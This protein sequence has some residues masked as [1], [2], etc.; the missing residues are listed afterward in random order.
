ML[1]RLHIADLAS[2]SAGLSVSRNDVAPLEF[3][4]RTSELKN[5]VNGPSLLTP[6][7]SKEMV[8]HW[9]TTFGVQ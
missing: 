4:P 5:A 8:Q 9:R 1:R 7:R 2:A 6:Q 3:L